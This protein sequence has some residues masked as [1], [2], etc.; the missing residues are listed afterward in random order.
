MSEPFDLLVFIGRFSPPHHGH[1][2]VMQQALNRAKYLL[3]LLGSS[4]VALSMRNPFNVELREKLIYAGLD[5]IVA[6]GHS[7]VLVEPVED[8]A[9]RD[10][11][12]IRRVQ[13]RVAETVARL[14]GRVAAKPRVGLIGHAKD[15]SSYYLKL[16]PDFG[17]VEVENYRSLDSTRIRAA[18][19]ER[20]LTQIDDAI[21]HI[22][23]DDMTPVRVANLLAEWA[24]QDTRA[25]GLWAEHEHIVRYKQQWASA[26]YPPTFVTTDA[27]VVQAGHVLM[28]KRGVMPGAGQWALPGGFLKPAE[29]LIESCLRE[30]TEETRIKLPYNI[31]RSCVKV[32]PRVFDNPYRSVRG[33]T[34]TNAFLID[35]SGPGGTELI[36][37]RGGDDAA[38]AQWRRWSEIEARECFED[39]YHIVDAMLG[40]A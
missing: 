20:P 15:H 40:A 6:D 32:G 5:E 12:W 35:V 2:R 13:E 21:A 28:V 24:R 17:S 14:K 27:V 39:H 3:V 37:V 4:N 7:R 10:H 11:A 30:L 19:F 22:K 31:L 25:A 18:L 26:P 8:F 1:F 38:R 16:F 29:T 23:R 36:K 33:R 34:I 9:Y